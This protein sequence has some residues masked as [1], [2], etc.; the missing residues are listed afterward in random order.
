MTDFT[1][2]EVNQMVENID[3]HDD[4]DGVPPQDGEQQPGEEPKTDG[5]NF[6]TI[7][8]LMKH[9]LAYKTDGGKEVEEDLQTILQRAS[10]GYHFAQRMNEYNQLMDKY[11]TELKPQVDQAS[12]L[13]EKY[14][15]FEDYAKE[16]PDWYDHWNN[17]YE[18]RHTLNQQLGEGAPPEAANIQSMLKE[19]LSQELGPVKE[20]MSSQAQARQEAQLNEQDSILDTAV[21]KTRE[22]FSN[23]DFDRTD[24]ATGKSLELDVLEFM[25]KSGIQDFNAAFKAF[26]HD[27]LV[28]LQVEQT[29]EQQQKSEADRKK[30]GILDIKSTPTPKRQPNFQGKNLDQLMDMALQDKEI[31]GA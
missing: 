30:N 28:K 10:G 4:I 18:N 23:V 31:F 6:K 12:Q 25:H 7:D 8:D 11:N 1:E 2:E 26:Y 29:L 17:A 9:K 14:G 13:K 24:P 21:K 5:F 19:M 3:K 22:Q 15:K 16:N 20:F 27:N